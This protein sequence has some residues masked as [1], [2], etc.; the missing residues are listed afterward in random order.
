MTQSLINFVIDLP[1][2]IKYP[3]LTN[4]PLD[5]L[6]EFHCKMGNIQLRERVLERRKRAWE[7]AIQGVE[8][9][10]KLVKGVAGLVERV[11]EREDKMF[12]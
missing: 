9:T 8:E 6:K 10:E 5:C 4:E 7:I 2:F 12:K 11:R 1:T 3:G